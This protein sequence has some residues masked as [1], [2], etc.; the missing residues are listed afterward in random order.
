MEILW[1][2]FFWKFCPCWWL[3]CFAWSRILGANFE[4]IGFFENVN[5]PSPI[6]HINFKNI[7]L[8]VFFHENPQTSNPPSFIFGQILRIFEW[9]RLHLSEARTFPKEQELRSRKDAW[10]QILRHHINYQPFL[11]ISSPLVA[12]NSCCMENTLGAP[13]GCALPA[14][15]DLKKFSALLEKNS[16][17]T[18]K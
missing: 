1:W 8:L 15:K 13:M 7:H 14:G 6:T 3:G 17:F 11:F 10:T 2:N 18:L 4:L 12:K 16:H 5:L 9:I